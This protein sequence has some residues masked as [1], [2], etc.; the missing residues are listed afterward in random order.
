[1]TGQTQDGQ[2]GGGRVDAAP[3]DGTARD[4]GAGRGRGTAVSEQG[5]APGVGVRVRYFA[6][7]AAAA[8]TEGELVVLPA[9]ATLGDLRA[10]VLDL[11]PAMERVL[12]VATTLVDEVAVSQGGFPLP[13]GVG[14]DVLPPFAGG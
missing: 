7:A 8:G 10:R 1:M 11:H 2:Q 12:A 13:D 3:G 14:V 6:G 5:G 9:G 4:A